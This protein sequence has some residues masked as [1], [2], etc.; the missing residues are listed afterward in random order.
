M[1]RRR[2]AQRHTRR[3]GNERTARPAPPAPGSSLPSSPRTPLA[4]H[5]RARTVRRAHGGASALVSEAAS[6]GG[7]G[8]T[9]AGVGRV[10][11]GTARWVGSTAHVN[12]LPY[13]TEQDGQAR[14][15]GRARNGCGSVRFVFVRWVRASRPV[16]AARAGRCA[17]AFAWR[18][19]VVRFNGRRVCCTCT[20]RVL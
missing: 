4:S 13:L 11:L 3:A 8:C 18:L 19:V 5:R 16:H 10:R 12:S 17:S 7:L 2:A 1:A 9:G 20:C 14:S 6:W 15:R